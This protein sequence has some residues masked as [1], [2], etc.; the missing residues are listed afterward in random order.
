MQFS[1]C[2]HIS[3]CHELSPWMWD[4]MSGFSVFILFQLHNI[5]SLLLLSS[6]YTLLSSLYV[7]ISSSYCLKF[8]CSFRSFAVFWYLREGDELAPLSSVESLLSPSS[9]VKALHSKL[10][11]KMYREHRDD[12]IRKPNNW[13]EKV[14]KSRHTT[15]FLMSPVYPRLLSYPKSFLCILYKAARNVSRLKICGSTGIATEAFHYAM[16]W[17]NEVFWLLSYT[18]VEKKEHCRKTVF[19][20]TDRKSVV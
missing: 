18:T 14:H 1:K 7:S 6:R 11:L 12:A 5:D 19:S 13:L 10:F 20:C 9:S 2:L 15:E 17:R 3:S 16:Q 4:T 8:N